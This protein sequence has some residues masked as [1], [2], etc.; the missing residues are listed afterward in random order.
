M[1]G[2]CIIW[3]AFFHCFSVYDTGRYPWPLSLARFPEYLGTCAGQ[4]VTGWLNCFLDGLFASLFQR[5]PQAVGVFLLL[6]GFSLTLGLHKSAPGKQRWTAWYGR[7]LLRLF[8]LY[9]AAHLIYLISPFINRTGP[10]DYRFLL[11]LLGDRVWPADTMFFYLNPSWW[12][13]GLLLELYLVFPVLYRLLQRLG[14][15]V[16]LCICAAIT[17]GSRYLIFGVLEANGNFLMGAFFGCRLWEFAAGMVLGALFSQQPLTVEKML[18]SWPMLASGLFLYLLGG[19]SYRPGL[20]LAF[21]D[22]LIGTGLFIIVAQASRLFERMAVIGPLLPVAGM[23]SFGIY[24]LHQPYVVY[25]GE[26]L[27][28]QPMTIFIFAGAGLIMI[29]AAGAILIERGIQKA[30]NNIFT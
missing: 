27:Q 7:R 20:T 4:S 15:A 13:F 26:R 9:W 25:F 11:S 14:L 12:F 5:G 21:T 29:V 6:S 23:Y 30:S 1:K 2:V 24:L 3:I 16:F 22:G 19:A 28:R 18:F 10:I 17:I 8:P